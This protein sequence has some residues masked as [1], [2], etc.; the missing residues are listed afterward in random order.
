MLTQSARE[1]LEN[2]QY[3][4]VGN[5][6]AVKVCGWTKN[7]I[8]GEGGC[9]KLTFYGIMS[10]QCMQMTTSISCANRCTF[11]WRG[12]KAPVSKDWKWAVDDPKE[13]IEGSKKAHRKLLSGFG[14]SKNANPKVYEKSKTIKHVALSLTGEPIFYPRINEAIEEFNK[15]GVSTFLVTNAQYPEQIRDLKP[16]TQLYISVDAPTKETL[17]HIDNPLFKDNWERM[18]QSLDYL[19]QKKQRTCIR[20]TMVKDV[21]N[22]AFEKYAELIKR[23][24]SDFVEIKAYMF[25]GASTLRLKKDN[26]PK[27]EEVVAYAKEL[28]K[29]LPE[30]E[31]VSEHISSRVVMLAKK[32]F[33]IDG[34]WHTWIDFEKYHELVNS[35]NNFSTDD[36]L[37]ETPHTGLSGKKT[38]DFIPK[39]ARKKMMRKQAAISSGDTV[40]TIPD[41]L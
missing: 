37:K 14:G 36:Y 5:H 32:K 3:R 9:Y 12:Y 21:N 24:N 34:K 38:D 19:A 28:E 18:L 33:K 7:M 30:Y 2:Q 29:Y 15:Q 41:T 39:R 20:L 17:K 16:V 6:S 11:C 31:I 8:K 10:N 35:G 26:M 40:Q 27:H 23:G 1:E 22:H 25:V 4:I 13:I